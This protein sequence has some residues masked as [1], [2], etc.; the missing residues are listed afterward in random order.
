MRMFQCTIVQMFV[1]AGWFAI[2]GGMSNVNAAPA[3][4]RVG[5]LSAKA[6]SGRI[7]VRSNR[8]DLPAGAALTMTRQK[9]AATLEWV[10]TVV[11][12]RKGRG[13]AGAKVAPSILAAY[14]ISIDEGKTAWQ[15][16]A[17]SPVRVTVTLD[18][19][20]AAA[21]SANL[22]IVH[23]ADD[24]TAEALDASRYGFDRDPA[25]KAITGFWVDATGFS[26]YAI[27]DQSILK[28]SFYNGSTHVGDEY[29]KSGET[30]YDPGIGPGGL[31]YGETFV[32]WA[33]TS[34]ATTGKTIE[35]LNAELTGTPGFASIYASNPDGITLYAIIK[36]A[37]Y[38]RYL[39]QSGDE[40][41]VLKTEIV[42]TDASAAER[43]FTIVDGASYA[44]A[45]HLTFESWL[46]SDGEIYNKN[47]TV[48]LTD[49]LDLYIKVEGRYWLVFDANAGGPGSGATYT[50]PQL[51][52]S[53][54]SGTTLS[55]PADPQ[56]TGYEFVGWNTQPN[57]S[58]TTWTDANFNSAITDDVTLYAQWN[59][60]PVYYYV[61][62]WQQ[63]ASDTSKYNYMGSDRRSANTGDTVN[64]TTADTT[65]GGTAGSEFGYYFTYN[66]TKSDTSV[67]VKPDG[68]T[69]L[70]VYY[71]R[72]VITY[73]FQGIGETTTIPAHYEEA[74]YGRY[75]LIDGNYVQLYRLRSNGWEYRALQDNNTYSTVYYQSGNNSYT[76]YNGTRYSLVAATTVQQESFSGLYGTRFTEWPDAGSGKTWTDGTYNYPLALTLFDPLS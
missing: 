12:A 50:P 16:T 58:G 42:A 24:G 72:R 27:S 69:M 29:V 45:E 15:P 13:L 51:Y 14:D 39:T 10:N 59:P 76:Q 26:I 11:K 31:K 54:A 44:A 48:T 62:Y 66:A 23:I 3:N 70:N 32:G 22:G 57:G 2:F 36:K 18:E 30:L 25:T 1:I 7:A 71:D 47:D 41:V 4:G 73:N 43:T 33:T 6:H 55:K 34:T 60:L 35:A 49:H 63:S 28:Y 38:L 20:V 21:E 8:G 61:I 67:E 64:T 46:G 17:G 19:P 40:L 65:K 37:Y 56:W 75:G 74:Q 68:T 9:D 5:Q 53:G 52:V